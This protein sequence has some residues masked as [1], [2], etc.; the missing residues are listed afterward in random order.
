MEKLIS[1]IPPPPRVPRVDG[2]S[3]LAP[4]VELLDSDPPNAASADRL[5]APR[6]RSREL[7]RR[8]LMLQAGGAVLAALLLGAAIFWLTR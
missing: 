7:A 5:S 8:R 6:W 4:G 3:P 2:T 1:R